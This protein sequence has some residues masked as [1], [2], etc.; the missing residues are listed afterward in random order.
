MQNQTKVL[1]FLIKFA[2][3]DTPGLGDQSQ[4]KPKKPSQNT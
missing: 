4:Q 2:N 1:K 3:I